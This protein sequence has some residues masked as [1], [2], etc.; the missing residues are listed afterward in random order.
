MR[1]LFKAL[2]GT[3][4][5]GAMALGSA[6]PA[7]ADD[8][9]YRDR[10]R[11][12]I[13]AGEVIAGAVIL[14]GIA[15]ILGGRDRYDDRRYRDGRYDD[16]R[17]RDRRYYDDRYSRRGNPRR[18]V[19]QCVRAA[20]RDARRY[21]YR[22]ADVTEIRDVDNTRYGFRV[23]GSLIVDAGRGYRGY[24]RSSRY[25]RRDYRRGYDRTDQGRFTCHVE[26]G[27]VTDIDYRGIRGLR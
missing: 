15:A 11:D 9:R 20:E 18:A 10:D 6:S 19:E 5:A 2:V 27:R 14:G 17:Y 7:L 24:E 12:G 26:R 22:Y 3:A 8:H 21:G 4:T 25:D 16:R 23:R 13:S 1:T